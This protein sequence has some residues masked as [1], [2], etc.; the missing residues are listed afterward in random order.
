VDVA[1]RYIRAA[2]NTEEFQNTDMAMVHA[3]LAAWN[4]RVKMLIASHTTGEGS[5]PPSY[6]SDMEK[7]DDGDMGSLVS[8]DADAAP[9]PEP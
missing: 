2:L 7:E 9:E 4:S 6:P 5:P 1:S 3:L 8:P